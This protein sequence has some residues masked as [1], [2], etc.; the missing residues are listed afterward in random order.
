LI[1]NSHIEIV[2][3]ESC[4]STNDAIVPYIKKQSNQKPVIVISKEQT[5]G[6]G[7]RGK[8]WLSPNNAGWYFSLYLPFLNLP[9]PSAHLINWVV[10]KA[11]IEHLYNC[12]LESIQ[13]KWPNDIYTDNGKLGGILVENNLQGNTIKSAIIGIG[14]NQEPIRVDGSIFGTTSLAEEEVKFYGKPKENIV[15][16]CE[17]IIEAFNQPLINLE[18]L[19]NYLW[20]FAYGKS[21]SFNFNLN[22]QIIV[23][24][25]KQMKAN[26][27]LVIND[28]NTGKDIPV[29]SGSLVWLNEI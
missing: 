18:G 4:S 28:S 13:F 1:E 11:V 5:A 16:I 21:R 6:K 10:L 27:F 7:Q 14:I 8:K 23:G 9:S 17:Q 19:Q 22:G 29:Q 12:G 26:G 15:A 24:Q 3:L 20:Q 2:E 25:I